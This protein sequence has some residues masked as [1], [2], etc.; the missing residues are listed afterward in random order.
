MMKR[1]QIKRL[2]IVFFSIVILSL[3]ACSSSTP[4]PLVADSESV[5][6]TITSEQS[7][8]CSEP[9]SEEIKTEYE[10]A[11]DVDYRY[12]SKSKENLKLGFPEEIERDG[13]IY[14]YTGMADYNVE[15]EIE[16]V[17]STVSVAVE[18]KK[19]L[20]RSISYKSKKSGQT[21][22]LSAEDSY[23]NWGELKKIPKKVTEEVDW[24]VRMDA[25]EIEPTRQITYFN[26]YTN[27]EE[28]VTAKLV[29]KVASDPVWCK[30]EEP[31]TGTFSKSQGDIENFS[32]SLFVDGKQY[33]VPVNMDGNYPSWDTYQSDI[34]KILNL[35]PAEYRI[36]GAGWKG[37]IYWGEEYYQPLDSIVA[38]QYR[39]AI[40]PFEALCRSY[41]AVYEAEG[42]SLGYQTDVTYFAPIE[43]LEKKYTKEELKPDLETIYKVKVTAKYVEKR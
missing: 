4:T 6:E 34:L 18:E 17:E 40:Y 33:T 3:T 39:D 1:N 13:K 23:I 5:H 36:T 10:D 28:T 35:S 25:V 31:I 16:A 38:V 26:R 20:D 32:T 22:Y 30:A 24:G 29:S 8:P 21:Y 12:I 15:E 11:I 19:E 2:G 9:V 14:V 27:R 7:N 37:D 41:K 43:A 42:E